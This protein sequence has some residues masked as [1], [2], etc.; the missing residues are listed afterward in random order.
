M[1]SAR[2]LVDRVFE[3]RPTHCFD[4][5]GRI[6]KIPGLKR[7]TSWSQADGFAGLY[8]DEDGQAYEVTVRPAAYAKHSGIRKETGAGAGTMRPA[9]LVR[10]Q[11]RRPSSE[12]LPLP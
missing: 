4:L 11:P 7:V 5:L 3:S 12:P 1:A 8:R 6:S 2:N 9:D 10:R